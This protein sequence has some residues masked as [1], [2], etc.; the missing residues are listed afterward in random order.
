MAAVQRLRLAWPPGLAGAAVAMAA[1]QSRGRPAARSPVPLR[2]LI[3]AMVGLE[4]RSVVALARPL[5]LAERPQGFAR[6][7]LPM[8]LV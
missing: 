6:A 4:W 2:A 5:G 7:M 1:A 3:V 8:A